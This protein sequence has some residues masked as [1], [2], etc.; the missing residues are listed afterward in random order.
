M[1]KNFTSKLMLVLI[2]A[3]LSFSVQAQG[4]KERT[5]DKKF[6]VLA[7]ASAGEMYAELA[8]KSDATDHQIRRA[9]ECNRLTGNSVDAEKWYAKLSTHSGVKAE[10]FYHYAQM[11]KMNEKYDLANKMMARFGSMNTSNS[12][13]KAHSDNANYVAELKSTPNKYDIAIFGVN[14]K[15][16]DF[17]PNYYT[18]DGES[19]VVFASA[20]TA[21]TT[22]LN[23][24][25]Q[26]DGSNFLDAYRAQVGGDG[27]NVKV[28]RFDRGIKSKYHEGPVSFSNNGTIMYLTRSNYLNRKKGLDSAMHNNL[29]LYISR[30]DSNGKWGE[31]SNFTHNSD[32][33][34]VGH[35]SVTEDGK[36]MFFAS[37]MPGSKGETDIWMSKL[38]GNAWS[39]PVN[40][41]AV[42][43]EGKEMFPFISKNNN[44]YFSTDGFVGLG[45]QDV[46]KAQG[47]GSGY[48]AEPEN[49]MYPL[50]TNHDDFGLIINDSETEGYFSSNR[51]GGDAKGDDDIYRFKTTSSPVITEVKE[52][53]KKKE[54][55]KLIGKVLDTKSNEPISG[56]SVKL[57]DKKTGEVEEYITDENGS[58]ANMMEG[59]PCP[60]YEMDYDVIIEKKG[61]LTKTVA[62]NKT[63]DKPGTINLNEY[64]NTKIQ[65]N[66]AGGDVTEFCE[67]DDILYDFDKSF[68]RP[69]AAIELDKLVSCMK[70]NPTMKIEIGSHTDC[71][72]SKRYN[73][74]LS[75]RRAKAAR[76]YVISKGI[77]S[78]RIYGRGYGETKLLNGC[79]CE[80]TNA[81]DCSEEEH[82]LNRRTEF[83]IVSGGN[84]VKNNSTNSF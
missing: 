77:D 30:K 35:A 84:G 17:G 4:M 37:D 16:S 22:L 82:Q 10:D 33:Y 81:S 51:D 56:V 41:E 29:K 45:G 38:E 36:T 69:D 46:Y 50:N 58:F 73:E 24:K 63:F 62:F 31:L 57:R 34:S 1:L 25:F 83:R 61:Y 9:A 71:R 7:Y 5:A 54:E 65:E 12:I 2:S 21:N 55:C 39:K 14:T 23:N 20:R 40:V 15:A 42:N 66:K 28:E 3:V 64:I 49:L 43:T 48:F 76:D 70:A 59:R 80:P 72:A 67:I 53:K 19:S 26:W 79:A 6:D 52:I 11:L 18:V 44:L 74:K 68:I 8:K 60:G 27:E 13:A 32:F 75:D 47:D 78:D